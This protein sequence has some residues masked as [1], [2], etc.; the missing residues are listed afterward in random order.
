[1]PLALRGTRHIADEVRPR[2]PR[3]AGPLDET[4]TVLQTL[5]GTWATTP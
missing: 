5:V 1:M 2:F 3:L 4:K